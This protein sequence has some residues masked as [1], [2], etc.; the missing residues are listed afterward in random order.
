MK[1]VSFSSLSSIVQRKV[2]NEMREDYAFRQHVIY[3]IRKDIAAELNGY[4]KNEM[5]E[6]FIKFP[7]LGEFVENLSLSFV[8]HY[9]VKT[10]R[11]LEH[12]INNSLDDRFL[13]PFPPEIYYENF[14]SAR[15]RYSSDADKPVMISGFFGE[16][17]GNDLGET[18]EMIFETLYSSVK[19]SGE[20]LLYHSR[21]I[22]EKCF[23]EKYVK[24]YI[25]LM[26]FRFSED[27]IIRF[28]GRTL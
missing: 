1:I 4:S 25:E 20:Y 9:Q 27:G 21:E 11:Y 12:F 2:I 18:D 8:V 10:K 19:D 6:V 5:R 22:Y 15:I 16:L 7:C 3:L 17:R 28:A 13:F 26:D 23:S 14:S 24:D